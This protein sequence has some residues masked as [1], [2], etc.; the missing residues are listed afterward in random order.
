M[1]ISIEAQ[2]GA[3]KS[4]LIDQLKTA[5]FHKPHLVIPE[6][7]GEWTSIKDESGKNILELFY[8]DK[9]KYS[10]MFQS[11][12]L[13]SRV[14]HLLKTV[15]ENPNTIIVC[16]RSHLTD[17]MVFAQSLLE[18]EDLQTIEMTVYKQW[19]EMIRDLFKLNISGFV[20]L[21]ASPETCMKRIIE[22]SRSGESTIDMSYLNLLHEKHED[23]LYT[24]NGF[25]KQSGKPVLVLDGEIHKSSTGREEQLAT[26]VEF[27]RKI[28]HDRPDWCW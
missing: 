3:G 28:E 16:E 17:L 26:I 23:W 21:K 27:V 13:F 19:H 22:R 15:K 10:Y 11:F 25:D 2:I 18:L 6:Q 4:S 5:K 12:V 8:T 24:K 7:V 14:H 9:K 1:I 20:Y